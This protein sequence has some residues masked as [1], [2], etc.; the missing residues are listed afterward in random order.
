MLFWSKIGTSIIHGC[1]IFHLSINFPRSHSGST[2][3]RPIWAHPLKFFLSP[4]WMALSYSTVLLLSPG[5]FQ[6]FHLYYSFS[7]ILVLLGLSSG[8]T[9]SL[10]MNQLHFQ[11][12]EGLL[13]RNGGTRWKMMHHLMWLSNI[14]SSIPHEFQLVMICHNFFSRNSSSKPCAQQ[15]KPLKNSRKS[16]MKEAQVFPKKTLM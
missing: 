9:S 15:Q 7:A 10:L 5:N 16:L 14:F 13:R 1:Y 2:I 4:F 11:L 8:I 3:G 6:L 12:L